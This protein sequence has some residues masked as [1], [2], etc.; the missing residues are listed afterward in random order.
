MLE[1]LVP[2]DNI[3]RPAH[4]VAQVQR[5]VTLTANVHRVALENTKQS[6]TLGVQVA[7]IAR[8]D[9]LL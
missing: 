3:A 5:N 7:T 8:Q 2:L 9:M 4:L 1:R 6:Q